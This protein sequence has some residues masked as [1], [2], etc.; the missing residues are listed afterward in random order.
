MFYINE[1]DKRTG[2]TKRVEIT[3]HNVDTLCPVCG[4]QFKVNLNEVFADQGENDLMATRVLCGDCAKA[5]LEKLGA[6]VTAET[7]KDVLVK[8]KSP[9]IPANK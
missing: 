8:T 1:Y 5:T 3:P 4:C 9:A 6:D 2:R 7:L